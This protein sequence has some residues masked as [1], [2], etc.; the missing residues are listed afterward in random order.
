[1]VQK[2]RSWWKGNYQE[3]V[4]SFI[5]NSFVLDVGCGS[6]KVLPEAVGIDINLWS[7]PDILASAESTPFRDGSFDHVTCLE[8]I[9]HVDDP[10]LVFDELRR[11]LKIDGSLLVTTPNSNWL[12]SLLL[13]GWL[14]FLRFTGQP[15]EDWN[16]EHKHTLNTVA[17]E[18]LAERRFT[19]RSRKRINLFLMMYELV[20]TKFDDKS[21]RG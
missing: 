21:R 6:H 9:E 12:W 13:W 17:L 1:M 8:V 10:A 20:K 2:F 11:V 5:S 14:K 3:Y 15:M 4:R 18:R 19:V 16:T 7:R